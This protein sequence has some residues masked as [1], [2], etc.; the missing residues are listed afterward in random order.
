MSR[1]PLG[2]EGR[3]ETPRVEDLGA[4]LEAVKAKVKK[5]K[6][7]EAEADAKAKAERT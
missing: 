4:E 3:A 1:V 5:V 6:A 2:L 7:Q